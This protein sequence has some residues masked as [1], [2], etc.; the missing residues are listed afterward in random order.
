MYRGTS[1]SDGGIFRI[2]NKQDLVFY[3]TRHVPFELL[4]PVRRARKAVQ[5]TLHSV[6]CHLQS[7]K[8]VHFIRFFLFLGGGGGEVDL[9]DDSV[10]CLGVPMGLS[11][12]VILGG[13]GRTVL[14]KNNNHNVSIEV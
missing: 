2:I 4:H 8:Q 11:K 9:P 12:T 5:G 13:G 3:S 14:V 6:P 1:T 10:L 7:V